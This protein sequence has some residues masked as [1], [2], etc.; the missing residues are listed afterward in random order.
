MRDNLQGLKALCYGD[1]SGLSPF[2]VRTRFER[3][4]YGLM[5]EYS[6]KTFGSSPNGLSADHLKRF[7]DQISMDQEI[8]STSGQSCMRVFAMISELHAEFTQLCDTSN[9]SDD[10]QDPRITWCR[11]DILQLCNFVSENFQP[12]A[13]GSFLS[14]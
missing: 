7:T 3:H 6:V 11:D 2:Q 8:K 10:G 4:L 5:F 9:W 12:D 1:L 14:A 13:R